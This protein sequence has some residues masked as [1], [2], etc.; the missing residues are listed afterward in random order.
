MT[1]VLSIIRD[2]LKANGYDGL[3]QCDWTTRRN[4]GCSCPIDDLVPCGESFADCVPAYRWECDGCPLLMEP[5]SDMA[6]CE[7]EGHGCFR[8][9]KQEGEA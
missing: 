3:T 1:D 7:W 9:M 8:T 5:G 2:F 6:Y 4:D